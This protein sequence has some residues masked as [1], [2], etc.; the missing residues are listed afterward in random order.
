MF[1]VIFKRKSVRQFD[2][3]LKLSE[4][5][6]RA[7]Q[8]KID[9][10]IPLAQDIEVEFVIK[11]RKET[12]CRI[13]GEYCILAYTQDKPLWKENIGYMLEQLDLYLASLNVGCCWYGMGRTN[14][15]ERNGKRYAIMFCF[16]KSLESDFRKN[17]SEFDR[18]PADEIWT[19]VKAEEIAS[20]V[21]LAPSACNSQPW[22][23]E[24]DGKEIKIYRKAKTDNILTRALSKYFNGFDMGIFL[25][26]TE[27]TLRHYG[28]T[29][30]REIFDNEERQLT[31]LAK[32]NLKE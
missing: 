23:A 20:A 18:K 25:Y 10:L 31:L 3:K 32:Y 27:V 15:K 26:I 2:E 16:G 7:I 12:N 6:M 21:R 29:Y 19:G 11:N 28:K 30:N 8:S 24:F 14:E 9:S 22:K 13:N 1:D 5:E 17:V 4:S